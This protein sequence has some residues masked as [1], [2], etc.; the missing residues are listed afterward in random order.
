MKHSRGLKGILAIA[1]AF[2]LSAAGQAF[3]QSPIV[4]KLAHGATADQAIGKGMNKF[5]EL[6]DAKSAGK[7]K[8]NVYL[9]GS[10][11]SER[12]ALEAMVNGSVDFAGA[13]NANWAAFTDALL[14]MDLPYVFT[15]EAS[16]DK[17]L[18][19]SVGQEI[20]HRFEKSGFKLLMILN[21]GGFRDIVNTKK[22]IKVPSDLKGLKFRTTASPVEQAMFRNWGAIPT[23]VDWAEVY[24]ALSSDVVDGEFVMPTW[25]ATAK[26]Y[27]VLKYS[28][29]NDAVIGIQ[30]LAMMKDRFNG[31]PKD[32]QKAI[33]EAAHEAQEF[34]NKADN[35]QRDSAVATARKLGVQFY[36]P[37]PAQMKVWRTTGREIWKQFDSKIDQAFLKRILATQR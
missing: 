17:A 7:A 11:Y 9:A 23:A 24:T 19:G 6:V 3:A 30:T 16:F 4:L 33:L 18:H 27:E 36:N 29:Q 2:L 22:P 10:L 12:T 37:T 20:R 31:L 15:S 13:S 34:S 35:E 26:H 5:A 28:T 14:F 8:V 25:L 32:V 1:A 21:N